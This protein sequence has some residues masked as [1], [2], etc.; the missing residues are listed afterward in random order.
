MY[1]YMDTNCPFFFLW[2][3][4]ELKEMVYYDTILGYK[5]LQGGDRGGYAHGGTRGG[6]WTDTMR[7]D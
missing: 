3:K 5:I 1:T 4:I 7:T 2:L 6:F